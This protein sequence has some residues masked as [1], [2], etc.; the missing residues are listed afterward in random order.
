MYYLISAHTDVGIRKET[1]QD[2]FCIKEAETPLGKVVLAVILRWNGRSRK[3]RACQRDG[4]Q[5]L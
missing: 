3:R 2:S 4:Y 1:N 5:C